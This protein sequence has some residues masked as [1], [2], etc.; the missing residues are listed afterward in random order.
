MKRVGVLGSGVVGQVLAD[1]FLKHGFA[2]MRGSREP[3]KL[4]DWQGKAGAHASVGSFAEA[5]AYGDFIVLAVKGDAASAVLALAGADAL[6]G[7]LVLDATNPIE[8]APPVNGVLR[9]FTGPNDSLMERL[10]AQVPAARFVKAFSCVGNAVMV[11]PRLAGGPPTMFI[12]GN[13]EAAK[14]ETRAILTTFGWG[15][16]DMGSVEAARA[17]E[18]LCMLWCIPGF[19]QNRWQHAFRLLEG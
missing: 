2:V 14:T 3:A 8:A 6:A 4:A 12:C 17:I 13:D 7:K 10:Q 19:R 1:G 9:F 18:P 16:E 11:N 15:C 5:A